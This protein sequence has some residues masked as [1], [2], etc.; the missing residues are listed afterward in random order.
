MAATINRRLSILALDVSRVT[1]DVHMRRVGNTK[2][3]EFRRS[4]TEAD[5]LKDEDEEEG[6][7]AQSEGVGVLPP[8]FADARTREL[9]RGGLEKV[10]EAGGED[11]SGTEEPEEEKNDGKSVRVEKNVDPNDGRR[12]WRT[13]TPRRARDVVW[14]RHA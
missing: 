9:V 10:D 11:D 6:D 4:E 5:E 14:H 13:R 1:D 2:L 12:T 8:R 3:G 7:E